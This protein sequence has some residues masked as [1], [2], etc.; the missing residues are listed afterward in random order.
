MIGGT[1]LVGPYVMQEIFS[2]L[3]D[4]TV[5]TITRSGQ[6]L[7]TESAHKFDRNDIAEFSCLLQSLEPN[8]II[9]MIPFTVNDAHNTASTIANF[10]PNIPVVAISSIDI[11]SAYAKIHRTE[12]VPTQTCPIT[13][14]MTLRK[15]LGVEGAAYDK[16]HVEKTYFEIL[17]NV[18]IL[19]FPATY[20]WPDTT[21]FNPYLEL[22]LN[23][24]QDIKLSPQKAGWKFSRCL[25]KNA[26]Y[27]VLKA[28]QHEP[29]G[30]NIYNVAEEIAHSE[31][32]WCQKIASFCGWRGRILLDDELNDEVDFKQD[33]YVCSQK[34]RN[35]LGFFEK[36][37]PDD[38]LAE[39]IK[40]FAFEKLG[41]NYKKCY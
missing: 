9:D 38:G 8:H 39:A 1:G 41:R 18:T 33:F 23:G 15:E 3:P 14:D 32:D 17:P 13:E 12:D 27:A 6:K 28:L 31:I 11:Y 22:M 36:Y 25:H 26:A 20:G 7:F 40:L 16:L 37:S 21:R 24:Q 4:A 34:I 5:T 35:E 10:N 29:K 2:E 30:H 19:R